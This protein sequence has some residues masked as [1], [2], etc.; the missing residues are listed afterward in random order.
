M[1]I[2]VRRCSAKLLKNLILKHE[3]SPG[4]GLLFSVIRYCRN[5]GTCCV[6]FLVEAVEN[7]IGECCGFSGVLK[8]VIMLSIKVGI[9]LPSFFCNQTVTL[10]S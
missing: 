1:P 8:N 3:P 6:N 7:S 5:T 10:N 4:V 9:L 2:T